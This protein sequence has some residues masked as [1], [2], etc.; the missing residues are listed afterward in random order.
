MNVFHDPFL[1]KS[2]NS[3][4]LAVPSLVMAILLIVCCALSIV[5]RTFICAKVITDANPSTI[6]KNKRTMFFMDTTLDQI[7]CALNIWISLKIK[8]IH[9]SKYT[10]IVGK[11]QIFPSA[12]QFSLY[13]F[14][15]MRKIFLYLR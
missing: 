13:I 2:K 6:V 3:V 5:E 7:L 10:P 4:P 8:F 1:L 12:P 9:S 11:M 14:S 15:I